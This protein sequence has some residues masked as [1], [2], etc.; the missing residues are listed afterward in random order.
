M[1]APPVALPCAFP[2]APDL[3]I[4][5]PDSSNAV[6]YYS[7][8]GA[9]PFLASLVTSARTES[10]TV[11]TSTSECPIGDSLFGYWNTTGFLFLQNAALSSE[12]FHYFSPGQYTLVT[13]DIWGQT[14]YAYFQ[15][16]SA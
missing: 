6:G 12:Y 13:E 5:L 15:V 8:A 11:T 3:F 7:I 10:C 14:S 9:N 16:V 4:L 2:F 1:L